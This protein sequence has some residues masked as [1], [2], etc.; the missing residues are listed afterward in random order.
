MEDLATCLQEYVWVSSFPVVS[1]RTAWPTRFIS[2]STK[3][4]Q[5]RDHWPPM[6]ENIPYF[7][8]S[9]KVVVVAL[10]YS[11]KLTPDDTA[12]SFG[13]LD[14]PKDKYDSRSKCPKDLLLGLTSHVR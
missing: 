8:S 13:Q 3:V 4:D 7:T 11:C 14:F 2:T 6:Y 5:I 9:S 12:S 10:D 1:K